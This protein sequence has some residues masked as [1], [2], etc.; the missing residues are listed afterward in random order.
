MDTVTYPDSRVAQFIQQHFIPVK[1]A[2]KQNKKL[3]EDYFVRWTPNVV[4]ADDQGRVHERVEGYL[5]PEEFVARL[6]LG[7]GKYRL[8][9]KEFPQAAERFEEVTQRHS[10]TEAGA[11]ALYWLGVAHYKHTHDAAQLRP[12]WQRLSKDYPQ[13]EWTKRSQIPAMS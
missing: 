4:I 8:D 10:G 13:S 2:I 5:P 1:V 12:S 6:A 9:R 11:E 3:A 7:L